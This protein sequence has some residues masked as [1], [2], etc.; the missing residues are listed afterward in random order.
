MIN[1]FRWGMDGWI[2]S[3]IGYSAGNP[4]SADGEEFWTGDGGDHSLQAGWQ[5]PGTGA[6]GSCNT[7][8]FDFARGWRNVLHHRD[9][10]RTFPARRDAGKGSG[11]RQRAAGVRLFAVCRIIR[12]FSRRCSIRGRPTCRSIGWAQFTAAAG[13]CIYTGGA[14]PEKFNGSHFCSETTMSLVHQRI[15]EAERRDV[16][17]AAR[18]RAG[19][20]R[21]HRGHAISGFARSIRASDRTARFT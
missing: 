10:R 17:G 20:D 16:H 11:A 13:C 12:R 8:G 19:G 15:P 7:W 1:N 4:R 21:I 2:Y 9:L 18:N 5:R 3:A 6:S 14:W